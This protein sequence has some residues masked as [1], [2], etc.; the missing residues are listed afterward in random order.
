M[1]VAA[2]VRTS[3]M[4]QD[5]RLDGVSRVVCSLRCRS[6]WFPARCMLR[7]SFHTISL[8][9]ARFSG[10]SIISDPFSKGIAFGSNHVQ[11]SVHQIATP[12]HRGKHAFRTPPFHYCCPGTFA[13]S[14]FPFGALLALY[15]HIPVPILPAIG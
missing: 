5:H 9:V 6:F 11:R 14:D 3:N 13:T 10:M 2:S 12:L 7:S 1:E 4:L 8:L 15:I